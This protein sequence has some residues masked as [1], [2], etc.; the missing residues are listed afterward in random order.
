MGRGSPKGNWPRVKNWYVCCLWGKVAVEGV[1]AL[2][3]A[4]VVTGSILCLPVS[5]V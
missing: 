3:Y 2:G 4:S 1:Q 5:S